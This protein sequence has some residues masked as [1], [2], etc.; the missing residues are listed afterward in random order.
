MLLFQRKDEKLAWYDPKEQI[1]LE[2]SG[3]ESEIL[4]DQN[5]LGE[6]NQVHPAAQLSW[7]HDISLSMS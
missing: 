5:N 3:A 1:K 7:T 6:N 2:D 4:R